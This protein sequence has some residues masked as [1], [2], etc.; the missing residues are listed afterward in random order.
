LI[1]CWKMLTLCHCF[2]SR[3][4]HPFGNRRP[5]PVWARRAKDKVVPDS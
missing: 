5:G 1:A 3:E 4:K 2:V